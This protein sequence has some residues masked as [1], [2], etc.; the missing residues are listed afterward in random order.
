MSSPTDWRAISLTV[1]KTF[2]DEQ[3]RILVVESETLAENIPGEL[4]DGQDIAREVF[5]AR[6]RAAGILARLALA[7]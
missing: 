7:S 2:D 4:W 3:H 5:V 1:R 6:R